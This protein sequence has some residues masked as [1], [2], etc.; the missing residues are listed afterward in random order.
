M[1][2]VLVNMLGEYD[3]ADE[4][5][6]DALGILPGNLRCESSWVPAEERNRTNVVGGHSDFSHRRI[7]DTDREFLASTS[8]RGIVIAGILSQV[9]EVLILSS[10]PAS[11][12][13]A[14]GLFLAVERT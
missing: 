13:T 14:L 1:S 12:V 11:A 8:Q 5:L 9:L 7:A 2:W 6:R 4:K 3:L 10:F